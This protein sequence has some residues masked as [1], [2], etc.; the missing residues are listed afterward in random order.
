MDWYRPI[1]T[2]AVERCEDIAG[3]DHANH[4]TMRGYRDAIYRVHEET[5]LA[6]IVIFD[7]WAEYADLSQPAGCV[8]RTS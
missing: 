4:L 5:G 8:V 7:A 3:H 1:I 2:S 6:R